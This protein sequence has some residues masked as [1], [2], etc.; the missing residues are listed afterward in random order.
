MTNKTITA[1]EAKNRFA[2]MVDSARV[3]PI[4]IT[5]NDRAIAV[6]L[7][8]D[9]YSRLL[10]SDDAYWGEQAGKVQRS[11]EFLPPKESRDFLNAILNAPDTA[12]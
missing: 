11:G 1:T 9:E 6:V 4:T 10:V 12:L 3:E 8:P 7:S 2:D 5:R